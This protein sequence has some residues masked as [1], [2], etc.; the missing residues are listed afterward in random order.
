MSIRVA[1]NAGAFYPAKA[2][3]I[4]K[5]IHTFNEL[6]ESAPN[7][8]KK[9][10]LKP[11]AI[12]APHAGY[13]YSGF[14]AN[15]AHRALANKKAKRVVVIGPS[16]HVYF[17]GIS[18][19]NFNEYQTPLGNLPID[20]EYL[21]VMN[22]HFKFQFVPQAHRLEHSTETQMPF[23]AH[24][25][26]NVKVIEL[27]YGKIEYKELERIISWLLEDELTSVVISSDL[28]HFYT[29]ERAQV[30]DSI[31][32]EG[33]A[34]E[35]IAILDMGCEACGILGIKGIVASAKK[36]HLQSE[37]LDY[38]TSGDITGDKSKVVGYA[39]AAFYK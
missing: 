38:R 14:T 16:H 30:L 39:S 7:I 15:I 35:D 2:Q 26:P 28:S 12:I 24:Y 27:I 22:A 9:L 13:I 29:Q 6:L 17:E 32:L 11:E 3:E 19:S 31:C 23:I 34:K 37:I 4:E 25:Q 33:I 10:S 18:A 1:G 36:L 8:Q 21:T 20:L 5:L